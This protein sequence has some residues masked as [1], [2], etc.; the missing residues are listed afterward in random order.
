MQHRDKDVPATGQQ[1]L[2]QIVERW[3]AIVC[4]I[5]R[6]PLTS[7]EQKLAADPAGN[8]AFEVGTFAALQAAA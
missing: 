7:A 4:N 1:C 3:F 5:E 8:A 6:P 2:K